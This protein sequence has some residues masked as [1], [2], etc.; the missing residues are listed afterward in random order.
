MPDLN[1]LDVMTPTSIAYSGTSASINADKSVVFTTVSSLSLNGVFTSSYDNYMIVMRFTVPAIDQTLRYRL[2][3]SGTDNSTASS[4]VSQLMRADVTSISGA[5]VALN[6]GVLPEASNYTRN[7]VNI[8]VFGPKLTQYTSARAVDVSD[9]SDAYIYDV[10]S[11]HN[12]ATSY[13]GITIY[14]ELNN[15]TGLLTVFGYK[16]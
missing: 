11:T 5:R 8:Y 6:T 2:R 15:I 9:K 12:Q 4:Y 3:A 1:G 13:D 16:Q 14:P 10:A 7:G